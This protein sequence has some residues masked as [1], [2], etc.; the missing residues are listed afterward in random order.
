MKKKKEFR[1]EGRTRQGERGQ[2]KQHRERERPVCVK[3]CHNDAVK[4]CSE[5][6]AERET[7][8]AKSGKAT[9]QDRLTMDSKKTNSKKK[10]STTET[11]RARTCDILG[12][13]TVS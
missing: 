5:H 3:R 10:K 2:H 12:T 4:I 1:T 8:K 11:R 13:L 7:A 9:Q 6:E